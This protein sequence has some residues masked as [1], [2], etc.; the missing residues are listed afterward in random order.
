MQIFFLE[1]FDNNTKDIVENFRTREF[2][3]TVSFL[4][5]PVIR[6][7]DFQLTN[8]SEIKSIV[9]RA[10]LT[11]CGNDPLPIREI[12]HSDSFDGFLGIYVD[13]VNCSITNSVFPLSEK[14]AVVKPIVKGKLDTV[15]EL[16]STCFQLDFYVQNC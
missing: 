3:E 6:L 13:I 2:Q 15:L 1:F 9:K 4:E 5:T 11:H 8:L 7:S 10:K 14:K 12:A 16:F